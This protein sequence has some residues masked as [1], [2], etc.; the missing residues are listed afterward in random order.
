MPSPLRILAAIG[1]VVGLIAL[2][3]IERLL[4]GVLRR[5]PA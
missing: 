1:L 2:V 3:V 4:R 5:R